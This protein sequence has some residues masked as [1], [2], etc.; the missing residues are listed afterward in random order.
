MTESSLEAFDFI[1]PGVVSARWR[2]LMTLRMMHRATC[3]ELEAALKG[4]HQSVSSRLD[5]LTLMGLVS[6]EFGKRE[7]ANQPSESIYGLTPDATRIL[8]DRESFFFND[9][10]TTEIYTS[11][12][13]GS[14]RCV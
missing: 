13:V 6:P 14:V 2:T 4:K 10:A 3:S 5:E 8:T 7:R 12:F 9:T 1:Q 11:L